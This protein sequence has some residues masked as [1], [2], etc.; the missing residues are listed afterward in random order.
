M[1]R[2]Y[3]LLEA[4]IGAALVATV[5]VSLL[6]HVGDVSAESTRQAREMTAQ[7][8]AIREMEELR[9]LPFAAVTTAAR[10]A[11][12]T[13]SGNTR[14][15]QVGN[16]RYQIRRVVTLGTETVRTSSTF[17]ITFRDIEVEVSFPE[18]RAGRRSVFARTRIYRE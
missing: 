4:M 15:L 11:G 1:Q 7:Q 12:V 18:A 3:I 17:D 16:S 5:L 14:N 13:P 8:L 6:G 2:G 9:A 10:V